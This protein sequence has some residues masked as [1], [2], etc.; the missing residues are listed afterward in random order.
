[1]KRTSSFLMATALGLG[2]V[3]CQPQNKNQHQASD[4]RDSLNT[5]NL[6]MLVGTYTQPGESEGI[7]VYRFNTETGDADSVSMVAVQNPSYL[8]LTPDE[9]VVY[10]VG[11]NNDSE[12]AAHAFSFDKST[13]TLLPLNSMLTEGGSPCYIT[14]DKLG[15]TVMT[16][17]YGGGSVSVFASSAD[18]SLQP[19]PWV[20]PFEGHGLDSVRQA[21][22]HVHSVQ[23]M[24]DSSHLLV[25]DLGTDKL[26]RLSYD[27]HGFDGQSPV[28]VEQHLDITTEPGTGPRHVAFHPNGKYMYVIGEISGKV[29]MY[30]IQTAEMPLLQSIVADSVGAQGSGDIHVSPDGRF[31]YASNRL[32][33]DGIAIF[34]VEEA[35]GLLTHVGYQLTGIH[36]RN[37]AIT[38]NGKFLLVACRDSN[39]IQ[40]FQRDEQTGL[41]TDTQK[42]IAIHKPVCI[43]FASLGE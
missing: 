13:G 42:N 43:K 17:N 34:S 29:L 21:Q 4:N 33:A 16:A 22:S 27:A 2:L 8:T 18:G 11:E 20:Y 3:A 26:Y 10:A 7:Y 41:L 25:T 14:T 19:N 31:V 5:D 38:P 35:T 12:S 39:T 32:K 37:F 24:P 36:P 1:M 40:V 30:D 9:Q 15:K 6:Y 28:K 23:F